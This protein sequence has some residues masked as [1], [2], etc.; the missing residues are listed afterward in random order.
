LTIEDVT[1]APD[2]VYFI[3]SLKNKKQ[4]EVRAFRIEKQ[5]V[6]ELLIH[7]SST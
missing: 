1:L 6:K 3:V 7:E 4:P 5:A 2:A